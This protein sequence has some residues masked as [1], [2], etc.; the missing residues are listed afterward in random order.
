MLKEDFGID[1]DAHRARQVSAEMVEK[2][3]VVLA[4]AKAHKDKI[5]SCFPQAKGKVFTLN[6]FTFGSSR[7][8]SDPYGADLP[9]YR[10]CAR[11][12]LAAVEK[13][14]GKLNARKRGAALE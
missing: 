10:R 3:D 6:E 5:V 11:E 7:D 8:I 12:I 4:M 1:I 14:V 9:E 13:I 2:A